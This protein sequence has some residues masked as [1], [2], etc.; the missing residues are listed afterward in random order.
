MFDKLGAVIIDYTGI[1]DHVRIRYNGRED[2]V[3]LCS[4]CENQHLAIFDC[5]TLNQFIEGNAHVPWTVRIG[6]GVH[7]INNGFPATIP[8]YFTAYSEEEVEM[9]KKTI[10]TRGGIGIVRKSNSAPWV[11]G[12]KS[13]ACTISI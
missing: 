9:I 2:A 1:L 8:A 6:R 5:L 3:W 13:W 12:K 10:K 7:A 4:I 11:A